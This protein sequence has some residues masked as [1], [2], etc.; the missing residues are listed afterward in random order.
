[1]S[2][3]SKLPAL[4]PKS[5]CVVCGAPHDAT[6]CAHTATLG[7]SRHELLRVGDIQGHRDSVAWLS[8]L[9]APAR[10]RTVEEEIAFAEAMSAD[11]QAGVDRQLRAT[12][13]GA[14]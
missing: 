10:V 6:D 3:G 2:K 5:G 14:R 9:P 7:L 4:P 12:G 13:F 8:V 1:M 11:I